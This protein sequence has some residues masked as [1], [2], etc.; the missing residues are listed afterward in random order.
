VHN[1]NNNN[2][3]YT[4]NESS[5]RPDQPGCHGIT[6][7]KQG[8]IHALLYIRLKLAPKLKLLMELT[9]L[10]SEKSNFCRN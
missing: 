7:I 1:N 5:T 3:T 10:H 4:D 6:A 2:N 9:E 8:Y